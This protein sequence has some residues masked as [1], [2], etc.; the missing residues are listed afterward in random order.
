VINL[1]LLPDEP[2]SADDTPLP[3][4]VAKRWG[5]P[6]AHL[7]TENGMYYAVQDWMRGILGEAEVRK[8]LAYHRKNEPKLNSYIK[9]F[10]YKT[11]NN[12]VQKRPYANQDGLIFVLINTRLSSGRNRLVEIRNFI[13]GLS[14][15]FEYLKCSPVSSKQVTEFEFQNRLISTLTHFSNHD[16][17]E[18][19]PTSLGRKIDILVI[20]KHDE[21]QLSLS[22]EATFPCFLIECKVKPDEFYKAVGQLM[23]YRAEIQ[24][25]L[26]DIPPITLTLAMPYELIDDYMYAIASSIPICLISVVNG[27]A[28]NVVT[29]NPLFSLTQPN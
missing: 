10:P 23:C 21:S 16:I 11:V 9:I 14:A 19:Y 18:Y 5:F 25:D 27:T 8:S 4:I 15:T 29:G 3:L 26:P 20:P 13:A 6:L 2:S 17:Y 22:M 1:P 24:R 7:Q 28:I 12:K